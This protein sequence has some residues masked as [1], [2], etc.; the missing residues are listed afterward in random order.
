VEPEVVATSPCPVKGRVPVCCG[1]DSLK[2]VLAAGLAPALATLSTSCLC[3]GLRELLA[4]G[5]HDGASRRCCPGQMAL[6]KQSAGCC[7]E[8]KWSQSPVPPRTRRAYETHLSAG[9]TAVP[10]RSRQGDESLMGRRGMLHSCE[11]PHVVSYEEWRNAVDSHHLPAGTHSLA[12]RPGA[13]DRWTFRKG[14]A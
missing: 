13:L 1:F 8:A 5:Q 6:Q 10:S 11:T 4:Q 7:M 2:V 9:S 14:A 12:T 3:V